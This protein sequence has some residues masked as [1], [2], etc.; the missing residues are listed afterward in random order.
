M[1]S[2]TPEDINSVVFGY[3]KSYFWL[4]CILVIC[5]GLFTLAYSFIA[6]AMQ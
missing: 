5:A 2:R 6:T 3:I 4:A 1:A